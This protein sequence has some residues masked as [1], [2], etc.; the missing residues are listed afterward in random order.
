M[1]ELPSGNLSPAKEGVILLQRWNSQ[2][3]HME[4]KLSN[5][6]LADLKF[7][8]NIAKSVNLDRDVAACCKWPPFA[9]ALWG[10]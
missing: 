2:R 7:T 1:C 10:L 5:K 8:V 6:K 9:H 4:M 3:T